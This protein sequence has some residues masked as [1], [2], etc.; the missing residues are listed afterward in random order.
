MTSA[1]KSP[2]LPASTPILEIPTGLIRIFDRDLRLAGIPKSDDRGRTVDLHSLRHTFG[3]LLSKGGVAPRTAQA[4]LR[5][6]SV[7]LTMNVY[8]DPQLLDVLGALDVLPELS[9]DGEPNS[10]PQKAT[11][12]L[13]MASRFAPG[14]A[15]TGY[16]SSQ[17]TSILG[18]P[19]DDPAAGA[20]QPSASERCCPVNE[21]TPLTFADNGVQEERA[22]GF[23]PSTS[24]LGRCPDNPASFTASSF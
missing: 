21:N 10:A 11:G 8:T 23:E 1:S 9:L 14:F 12:T 4:A 22:N 2:K 13:G 18:K 16:K 20:E 5:H 7:D 3:T 19:H 6:S 15:P 17:A 24:S